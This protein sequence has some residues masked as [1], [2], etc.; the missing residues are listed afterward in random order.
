MH[1]RDLSPVSLMAE[2]HPFIPVYRCQ[3]S[4]VLTE[5][6]MSYVCVLVLFL[7][8]LHF[9]TPIPT[10]KATRFLSCAFTFSFFTGN[11]SKL[12]QLQHFISAHLIYAPRSLMKM[13][14]KMSQTDP[15]RTLLMSPSP[16]LCFPFRSPSPSPLFAIPH[17]SHTNLQLFPLN[18][19]FPMW[20]FIKRCP[21][22]SDLPHSLCPRI[23]FFFTKER[24][25]LPLVWSTVY[26]CSSNRSHSP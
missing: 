21:G 13:L 6:L 5:V 7:I 17:H 26:K 3:W 8:K 9:T 4:H 2:S 25:Q 15:W 24:C 19:M 12:C 22:R 23:F 18:Q 16:A 14:N 20:H 1:L 10:P 11:V